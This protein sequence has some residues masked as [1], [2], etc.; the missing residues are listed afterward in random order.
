MIVYKN[1]DIIYAELF[2]VFNFISVFVE[3]SLQM[4]II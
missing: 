4:K 1:I 3:K 2:I